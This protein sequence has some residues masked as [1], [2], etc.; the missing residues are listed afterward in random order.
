MAVVETVSLEL[1]LNVGSGW[2]S[3]SAL[4][5]PTQGTGV[6]RLALSGLA[7]PITIIP[8]GTDYSCMRGFLLS[9][10]MRDLPPCL[11][12]AA[13]SCLALTVDEAYQ[14]HQPRIPNIDKQP[15]TPNRN[16]FPNCY[17]T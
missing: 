17:P 15:R 16:H 10:V 5:G 3:S 2:T 6:G 11:G 1:E 14:D 7:Q 12:D 13:W 8:Y 4:A 9:D